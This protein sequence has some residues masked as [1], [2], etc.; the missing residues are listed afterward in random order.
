MLADAAA[1]ALAEGRAAAEALMVDTCVIF[2]PGT[3]TTDPDTGVV[4]PTLTQVYPDLSW[5]EDHPWVA[6][7][8]KIQ[9]TEP[10]ERTQDVGESEQTSLRLRVDLPVGSY[11]PAVG[12]VVTV[13]SSM[14]DPNLV[15]RRLRVVSLLHKSWATAYRLGV[16]EEV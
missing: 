2:R 10:Q 9:S 11:R 5:P 3:P 14:N 4:T 13:L 6:G 15:G 16:T 7:P 1:F 12:D 8:C